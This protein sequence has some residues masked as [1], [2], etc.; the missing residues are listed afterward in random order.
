MLVLPTIVGICGTVETQ[1]FA[2][3]NIKVGVCDLLLFR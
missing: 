2:S 1:Y 3:T